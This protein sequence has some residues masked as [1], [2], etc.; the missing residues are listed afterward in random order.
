MGLDVPTTFVRASF[1]KSFVFGCGGSS[2][3]HT[4]FSPV[5]VSRGYSLVA[6]LGLPVALA[7]LVTHGL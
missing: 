5:A 6:V 1:L 7:S 4:G 2:L 3:L